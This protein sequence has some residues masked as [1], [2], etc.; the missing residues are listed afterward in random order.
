LEAV[1][2]L[3]ADGESTSVLGQDDASAHSDEVFDDS[4]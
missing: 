2:Y 3:L 1:N 4:S